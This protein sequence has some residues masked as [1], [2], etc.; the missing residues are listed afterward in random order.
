VIDGVCDHDVVS[1]SGRYIN[2][3]YRDAIRLTELSLILGP[4]D[5]STSA[6]ANLDL[7]IAG[8]QNL[9]HVVGGITYEQSAIGKPLGF[10]G[11]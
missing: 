8:T 4:I 1:D 2:G 3:Q 6:T 10:T 7:D 5:E 9:H 11:K